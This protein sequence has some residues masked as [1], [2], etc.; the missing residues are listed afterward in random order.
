M[1][2]LNKEGRAVVV[3][4]KGTHS[5]AIVEQLCK[6]CP[7]QALLWLAP[8]CPQSQGKVK[9][10]SYQQLAALTPEQWVELVRFAP[11]VPCLGGFSSQGQRQLG[12]GAL[13]TAGAV[14]EAC[15]C[16]A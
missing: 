16:W 5:R 3:Q 7:E 8:E 2:R 4:P 9:G 10:L 14:P 13:G 6:S 15:G 12:R 11:R 1:E